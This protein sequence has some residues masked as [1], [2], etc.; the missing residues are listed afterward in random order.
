MRNL[1]KG[2]SILVVA[3]ML[4]SCNCFKDMANNIDDVKISCTPNVLVLNNGKVAVDIAAE[5][6]AKY[7]N[8]KASVK[9]TPI[10][11]YEGGIAEGETVLL[12]G[13]KVVSNGI[14]VVRN[15]VMTIN[16]HVEFNFVPA[17]AMADLKLLVEVKCKRGKCKEF[18]LVNAN[19]GT[20]CSKEEMA[21]YN[22]TDAQ[23]IA[24]LKAK[25]GLTIAKGVNTLQADLNFADAMLD[26]ANN[27][28]NVTTVV[29]KADIVYKIN[30]A[31]VSKKAMKTDEIAALKEKVG[32]NKANDRATQSVYVNG[33]ASPD[34]PEKFNDQLSEKRSKSGLKE[35]QA[36]LKEYGLNIDAAAYGEDW[37]G[38]QQAV[39]ESDIQDKNVI[40]QV[41]KMYTSSAERENEIKNLSSVFKTLK[42]TVLPTL[43][44]AQIVNSADITGKTDAEMTELVK[45]GK[46]A[47]MTA[48]ELL[49]IAEVNA[50]VAEAALKACAEKY[51]DARAYNNLGIVY[52][53]QGDFAAAQKAFEASAKAGN[54]SAELNNNLALINLAQGNTAKAAEYVKAASAETKA[55]AAAAQGD[56]T[57]AANTLK[58]QNAAIANIQNGNYNAALNN[59]AGDNS[60]KADYLRA[61]IYNKQGNVAE[62]K[63]K[64]NAAIAKD[65]ALAAKA[66]KDIN[67]VEVLK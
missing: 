48:E 23:A 45:A 11:V 4:A 41:L 34:G 2:A 59:L 19:E 57:A 44:R 28:K 46:A 27:Y 7:F 3:A 12:Q 60:A 8:K 49:H 5:M 31:K 58:G 36:L 15:E 55:L 47:E 43:R 18:T 61:I 40:L 26:A 1:I 14:V 17:M 67:L 66:A 63:A 53:E 24:A 37:D 29:T 51:N 10:L 22:G 6:P 25:C 21:V 64:L 20:I 30:D 39:A 62:A 56:Y 13:E 50:E 65:S 33:Y 32:E 35:V 54:T 42:S 16:R 38:F 9:V 52:A